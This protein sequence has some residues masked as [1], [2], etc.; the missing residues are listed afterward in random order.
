VATGPYVIY[1]L[2][3]IED[4]VRRLRRAGHH[5]E[6]LDV[7]IG[8]HPLDRFIDRPPFNGPAAPG[9]LRLELNG[10]VSTSIGLIIT[11]GRPAAGGGSIPDGSVPRLGHL[12]RGGQ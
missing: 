9:H 5:V 6:P 4:I 1:R 11:K 3:D 7:G 2:R 12:A 10:F 8:D